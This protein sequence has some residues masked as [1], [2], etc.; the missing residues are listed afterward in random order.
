MEDVQMAKHALV[1][2]ADGFEEIEGTTATDLL[3]RGGIAVTVA[4]LG[5]TEIRG[6]HDIR[7]T[8]DVSLTS[9]AGEFDAIVLP[10]GM[11]GTLHLVESGD[12]VRMVQQAY[13]AGKLCAA[14][15]AAPR[16]LDTAGILT[17]KKY[18]C[19]PGTEEK[20]DGGAK[21]DADVVRD[22]SVITG[23]GVGAAIPFSLEIIDY[24]IDTETAGAIARK[25]V[26]DWKK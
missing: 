5:G 13:S 4:G 7:Y 1:I 11:P 8:A 26:F 14:I 20:I 3:R 9:F 16:A 6:S 22:G 24:L 10:G 2:L 25:V 12:V 23:R 18:T 21:V 17:N 15:C 19:Y